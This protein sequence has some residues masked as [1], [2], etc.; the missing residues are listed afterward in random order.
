MRQSTPIL[1]VVQ[2]CLIWLTLVS[3]SPA[4]SPD[5]LVSSDSDVSALQA[6]DTKPFPLRIL[7]LGA[8]ITM[9]YKSKDGNGYRKWLRQQLRYAGWEVD[10]IGTMKNGTMHDNDHDGHIGWR[11]DQIASH[12]KQII[13][14]QPNLILLN[15]GTNDALQDYK[16]KTAGK[17]MDSLLTYLFDNIPNTTIILST[18]TYNGKKP[19]LATDISTQY[20]ELAAKRRARKERLVVADM[21]TF[22]K[23]KQ[24]VDK[25]HPTDAGYEEMASVW[26]AA[27]Q[28]A[29]KEGFLSAP[30]STSI[31]SGTISKAREKELDDSTGDPSL[32]AYTAPPQP[33]KI[34]N[35]S[36]RSRQWHIWA[37]AFQMIMMCIGFSCI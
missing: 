3:A 17:R 32:P 7:P 9:G 34:S 21:S 10:M 33:T 8:S 16:I 1:W 11:I 25:I 36:S 26:W 6:R 23:W 13:P 28:Q 31:S 2:A 22:I 19:Q 24:L 27:I 18:L 4:I 35:G 37:V 15:A 5:N 12:A 29:E 14:Q 30:E 20:L